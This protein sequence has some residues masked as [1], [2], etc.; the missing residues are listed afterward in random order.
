TY[1]EGCNDDVNKFLWSGLGWNP[2]ANVVDLLRDYS[3]FFIGGSA[4]EGFAQGL[5]ALER[6]WHG[7]DTAVTLAQ[8]QDLERHA[9]PQQRLNWRFQEA[10]YRAY[11]DAYVTR[12]QAAESEQEERAAA[13]LSNAA[14]NGS[15][16]AM[17]G[18][19]RILDADALPA[20]VRNLRARVFELAEGLFQSI[21]MQL[22]VPRYQAIAIGRGA[23][24]DAIDFALN[25]RV[26]LK[27]QFAEIRTLPDEKTRLARLER[28]VNWT[29]PGPGGF[30]DDLGDTA[31]QPHL[32][33]GL[34]YAQDPDFLK[35]PLVGFGDLPEQGWRVS[36]FTH[37]ETLGDTPLRMHYTD[38]D[39][40]AQ[41][42]LR[43]VYGGDSPKTQIRLVANGQYEIHPFRA[44]PAPIAPLEFE[45]PRAAT[46]TGDLIL[47][48]SKPAGGGGNGRGVQV[49]EVWLIRRQA[50]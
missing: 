47:E 45:I 34:P 12:R 1:S 40:K 23:N 5:M 17:S 22:S 9:T 36:W 48:W 24:L 21:H 31:R 35:S 29:D 4:S 6:N 8:F 2:G 42:V 33:P 46:R 25:N 37:A 41:Y 18:A 43:V 30:Y 28:I 26:W 14:H 11:Y 49:S 50:P 27:N 44:K 39:R 7:G 20:D 16:A 15:L 19:E 38:L 13:V 3:R 10:L 32:A